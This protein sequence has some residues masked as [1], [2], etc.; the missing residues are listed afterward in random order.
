MAF[1]SRLRNIAQE[2]GILLAPP[3]EIA[4]EASQIITS[5]H[6]YSPED[7]KLNFDELIDETH[8][9]TYSV[10]L[11][12]QEIYGKKILALVEEEIR[13]GNLSLPELFS[14]LDSFFLSLAQGR[15]SRVGASSEDIL[16]SLFKQLDYPF[17]EQVRIGGDKPDF[18]MP[19]GGRYRQNPMDCIIFT[20]KRTLRERWRQV[21]TEGASG[22]WYLATIDEQVSPNQLKNMLDRRV[23]LV[24]PARVKTARYAGAENVLSFTEFFKYHLDPAVERWRRNGAIPA[25]F[26]I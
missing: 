7:I 16:K 17:E 3:E 13:Q 4:N 20:S 18:V 6:N 14:D 12:Q 9:E 2:R 10:Y 21:T 15:R 23:N 22:V 8:T 1:K 25:D 11:R 24:V 19:S 26:P 5:K